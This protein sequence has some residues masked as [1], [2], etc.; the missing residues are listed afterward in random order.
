MKMTPYTDK[1]NAMLD[2]KVANIA[3]KVEGVADEFHGRTE[4]QLS[5]CFD[6]DE[7]NTNIELAIIFA[8][9]EL[10]EYVKQAAEVV[11]AFD[12]LSRAVAD[13]HAEWSLDDF[14][15]ELL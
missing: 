15:K 12:N 11:L 6:G 8:E 14:D 7:Y 5:I 10:N 2:S 13:A 9:R 4:S 3:D 1:I